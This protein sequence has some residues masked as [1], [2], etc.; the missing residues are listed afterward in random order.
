MLKMNKMHLSIYIK[1]N[2]RCLIQHYIITFLSKNFIRFYSS[3]NKFTE[4]NLKIVHQNLTARNEVIAIQPPPWLFHRAG[5]VL[6]H[7]FQFAALTIFNAFYPHSSH[8]Y[9]IVHYDSWLIIEVPW[10]CQG[11]VWGLAKFKFLFN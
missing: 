4:K 7:N 5:V 3:I 1:W 9:V 2:K 8:C 11:N 6:A 10:P